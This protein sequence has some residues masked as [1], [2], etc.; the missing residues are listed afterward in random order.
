MR[1]YEVEMKIV[2]TEVY[3][4]TAKDDADLIEKNKGGFVETEGNLLELIK[5][6]ID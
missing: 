5:L 6:K 2:K 3:H 4:I 1:T